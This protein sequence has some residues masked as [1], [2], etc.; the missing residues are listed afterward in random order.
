[1][2]AD[3][4][5]GGPLIVGEL[6]SSIKLVYNGTHSTSWRKKSPATERDCSVHLHV[7]RCL[8]YPCFTKTEEAYAPQPLFVW[9][10][11]AGGV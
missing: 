9:D 5:R 6:G 2:I 3:M 7:L 1:M 11:C 4:F 10:D 8:W